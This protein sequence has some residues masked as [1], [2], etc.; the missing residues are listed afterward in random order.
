MWRNSISVLAC[1]TCLMACTTDKDRLLPAGDTSMREVWDTQTGGSAG[2][3]AG[4]RL[5]DTRLM[6]RRPML[7]E[8]H[9]GDTTF[10]RLPNPDLVMY[11]FPHMAGGAPIPGYRTVFPMF[12]RVEYAM[13]GEALK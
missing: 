4:R 3:L 2:S 8:T 9:D 5:L 6:L 1:A 11:V 12:G 7:S 13:P 10:E